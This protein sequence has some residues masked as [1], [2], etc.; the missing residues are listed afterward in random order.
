MNHHMLHRM[1]L[2]A[3]IAYLAPG[4]IVNGQ[5]SP[6]SLPTTEP[7]RAGL[8]PVAQS[9]TVKP[10]LA[11]DPIGNPTP[12]PI[13][14]PT[15]PILDHVTSPALGSEKE[16]DDQL[17]IFSLMNAEATVTADQLKRL[18]P[19]LDVAIVADERTNQLLTRGSSKDLAMIEALLMKLDGTESRRQEKP[20]PKGASGSARSG[21]G[22][23]AL[24]EGHQN[25]PGATTGGGSGGFGGGGKG[26]GGF[27]GGGAFGSSGF[28]AGGFYSGA[29]GNREAIEKQLRDADTAAKAADAAAKAVDQRMKQ[30]NELLSQAESMTNKTE[31]S[32]KIYESLRQTMEEQRRAAEDQRRAYEAQRRAMEERLRSSDSGQVPW[33]ALLQQWKGYADPSMSDRSDFRVDKAADQRIKNLAAD[34]ARREKMANPTPDEEKETARHKDELKSLLRQQFE[35]QQKDQAAELKQMRERLD[36]LEKEISNRDQ[37]RESLIERRMDDLLASSGQEK[38]GTTPPPVPK[39]LNRPIS[40]LPPTTTYPQ[41]LNS[42]E[43][44]VPVPDPDHNHEPLHPKELR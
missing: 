21:G 12:T 20:A 5:D 13:P 29:P 27:G 16:P 18:L 30:M 11:A 8:A 3:L 4:A 15:K 39:K 7:P 24:F 9:A 33:D 42:S 38:P 36:R 37:S 23:G 22:G 1:A 43:A 35:T 2:I 25:Q 40:V 19:N 41:P 31:D 26:G 32:A 14:R 6:Q 17:K 44:P 10:Q 28:G 34:L